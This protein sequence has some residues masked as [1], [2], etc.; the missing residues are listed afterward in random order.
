MKRLTVFA[1]RPIALAFVGECRP[2]A[3]S[4]HRGLLARHICWRSYPQAS[5]VALAAEGAQPQLYT[6]EVVLAD[7]SAQA[8]APLKRDC[9][10]C[11]A[12]PWPKRNPSTFSASSPRRDGSVEKAPQADD[13]L[14]DELDTTPPEGRGPEALAGAGAS[15]PESLRADCTS[16]ESGA[17]GAV[18]DRVGRAHRARLQ[19]APSKGLSEER[20]SH[21]GLSSAA[22]RAG[23]AQIQFARASDFQVSP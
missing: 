23:S 13:K 15:E 17:V 4:F 11:A 10:D 9:G 2:D 18:A 5:G 3:K 7:Q 16:V 6:Q 20:R 8:A 12:P 21:D 19:L 14:A 1:D 22:T